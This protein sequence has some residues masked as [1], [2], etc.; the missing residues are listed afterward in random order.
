MT[1]SRFVIVEAGFGSVPRKGGVEGSGGGGGSNQP[2]GAP[3][4]GR[5]QARIRQRTRPVEQGP[6]V[7]APRNRACASVNGERGA[8]GRGGKARGERCDLRKE[9]APVTRGRHGVARHH[10]RCRRGERFEGLGGARRG[11][12]FRDWW[13]RSEPHGRQR[14]ETSPRRCNRLTPPKWCETTRAGRGGRSWRAIHPKVLERSDACRGR[15]KAG[16]GIGC[17]RRG[18]LWT[19][20]REE[21]RRATVGSQGPAGAGK[22]GAKVRRVW[23]ALEQSSAR[24]PAKGPRAKAPRVYTGSCEGSGAVANQPGSHDPHRLLPPRRRTISRAVRRE[25]APRR[26]SVDEETEWTR[27]RP[28]PRAPLRCEGGGT[29]RKIRTGP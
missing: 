7:P 17:R 26:A 14:D 23:H 20:P 22:V 1:S 5:A 24:G 12:R 4:R 15:E 3:S 27:F 25:L 16:G 2:R 18:D 19:T 21:T 6:E 10:G 29:G 11:N 28:C 13:K 9:E 8:E